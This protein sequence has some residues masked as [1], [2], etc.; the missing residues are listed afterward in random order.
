MW[1]P[2]KQLLTTIPAKEKKWLGICLASIYSWHV[3]PQ[4]QIKIE[5]FTLVLRNTMKVL[6]YNFSSGVSSVIWS[7]NVT[8]CNNFLLNKVKKSEWIPY[9]LIQSFL[10]IVSTLSVSTNLKVCYF[11]IHHASAAYSPWRTLFNECV[12]CMS[13]HTHAHTSLELF[14]RPL[15]MTSW[16]FQ[17]GAEMPQHS[18]VI[19]SHTSWARTHSGIMEAELLA[20]LFWIPLGFFWIAIDANGNDWWHAKYRGLPP[21]SSWEDWQTQKKKF[22]PLVG[23]KT[24]QQN[25]LAHKYCSTSFW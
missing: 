7:R 22:R 20:S 13:L 5:H 2:E 6:H 17:W 23:G 18:T 25:C 14:V 1:M 8:L 15:W 11:E 9:V 19:G 4:E 12:A 24:K 3:T 10:L 21:L 16:H